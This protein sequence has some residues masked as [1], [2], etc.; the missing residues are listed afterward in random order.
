MQCAV[1][2]SGSLLAKRIEQEGGVILQVTD[3]TGG[4][5]ETPL[6]VLGK[7]FLPA[8]AQTDLEN[9]PLLML[10]LHFWQFSAY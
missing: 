9:V 2:I 6:S 3:S 8:V 7:P 5:F 10:W 4:C 1:E